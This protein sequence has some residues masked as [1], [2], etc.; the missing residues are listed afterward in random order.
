MPLASL[1][2]APATRSIAELRP[3]EARL[4][5]MFRL[6]PLGPEA[7]TLLWSEL[8]H[9]LGAGRARACLSAFETLQAILKRAAWALP[10]MAEPET[11]ALTPDE[12]GLCRFVLRALEADREA[13]LEEAIFLVRPEAILPLTLAASRVALP[14]LCV[15]CRLRL[16]G[17]RCR[18]N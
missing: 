6:W 9:E 16:E 17:A 1:L 5:A 8:S 4:L 13:A 3:P 11:P 14:L 2:D 10:E 18:P 12:D 7:Q 15:E